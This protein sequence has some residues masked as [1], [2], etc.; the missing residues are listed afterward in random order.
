[1][2]DPLSNEQLNLN[3]LVLETNVKYLSEQ[4]NPIE[5]V[6]NS[7][8]TLQRY[9]DL[10]KQFENYTYRC[11]RCNNTNDLNLI[12]LIKFRYTCKNTHDCFI[13]FM[14]K[15]ESIPCCEL[16]SNCG[17]K[18]DKRGEKHV[19]YNNFIENKKWGY[20]CLT[21]NTDY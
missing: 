10:Y 3:G 8:A 16:T 15:T 11:F 19:R 14:K 1:L 6:E 2:K 21:H 9:E 7:D 4:L 13:R 18:C 12:D 20:V 17:H 5:L